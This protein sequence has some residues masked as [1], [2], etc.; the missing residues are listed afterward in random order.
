MLDRRRFFYA[1]AAAAASPQL[2]AAQRSAAPRT[3]NDA[4]PLPPAIASLSSLA[5]QARPITN[6]ERRQ[7]LERARQLLAQNQLD[8]MFVSWGTSLVYFSGI[9]WGGGERLFGMVLPAKGEPFFVTPAFEEDRARE[10]ISRGPF[11]ANP[12]VRTWQEDESPHQ[13][14]AQ[15]LRERGIATGSLGAE[16]TTKFVFADGI[17]KAAPQIKVVSASPSPPAAARSSPRM[18]ST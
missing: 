13:R 15:G 4:P 2:L 7:R 1:A 9:R 17:A 6:D 14:V 8:A 16:E 3:N 12:D 18:S 11:G 10:Q 5:A